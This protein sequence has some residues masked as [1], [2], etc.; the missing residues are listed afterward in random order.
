[1]PN[2]QTGKSTLGALHLQYLGGDDDWYSGASATISSPI[3]I[4]GAFASILKFAN[5]N[6]LN[7]VPE[8]QNMTKYDGSGI[9]TVTLNAN[10][11]GSDFVGVTGTLT[12]QNNSKYNMHINISAVNMETIDDNDYPTPFMGDVDVEPNKSLTLSFGTDYASPLLVGSEFHAYGV[13]NITYSG[14]TN[15][16][17]ISEFGQYKVLGEFTITLTQNS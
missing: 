7:I 5:E 9:A 14:I 4:S 10:G 6:S 2:E 3:T 15:L 1:M 17:A 11:G 16:E 12:L 13:N 8:A